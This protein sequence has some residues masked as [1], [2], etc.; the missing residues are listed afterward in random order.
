[1]K[2]K[3]ETAAYDLLRKTELRIENIRLQNANLTDIAHCVAD[4]IDLDT[5]DILVVDY[6][7]GTL[8]LDILNDCVNAGNIVGKKNL[9]KE[10]LDSLPGVETS[11]ETSFKSDGMLG[12]ISLEEKPAKD[13]LV[14]AEQ[15]TA[16]IM[17]AVSKR[18]LIFSSGP[19]VAEKQ[20]KD[21]NTPTIAD[22]LESEGYRAT[23]GETLKDDVYYISAR[24]R[25]AGEYGGYGYIISPA[26]LARKTR[27]TPLKQLQP[28][29]QRPQHLIS[30][31][32]K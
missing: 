26:E 31:I 11:P 20:I 15:M 4:V 32:L 23:P 8:T 18:V 6:R 25:E 10:K 3:T 14:L 29:I 24:L 27:T 21:T 2:K 22:R 13:A 5:S 16:E 7:D 28:W 9:L 17:D 19:E 1:M 12:W 30:A